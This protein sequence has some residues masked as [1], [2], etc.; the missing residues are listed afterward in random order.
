MLW[1]RR[2][3][4][5][6]W[7]PTRK[8][9]WRWSIAYQD[10]EGVPSSVR[11]HTWMT[12]PINNEK[13]ILEIMEEQLEQVIAPF[14]ATLMHMP[15]PG[16]TLTKEIKSV[17]IDHERR[18]IDVT[19]TVRVTPPLAPWMV[20]HPPIQSGGDQYTQPVMLTPGQR[21]VAAKII[22]NDYMGVGFQIGAD[23][24]DVYVDFLS[25][26]VLADDFMAVTSGD[27]STERKVGSVVHAIVEGRHT[28][29]PKIVGFVDFD[30]A[31]AGDD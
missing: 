25:M 12:L 5:W 26:P 31:T 2:L 10:I 3:W 16:E 17:M 13:R 15:G 24:P 4:R 18:N 27:P 21:R 14:V 9:F 1:A 20:G 7:T 28:T 30:Q 6:F 19:A 8:Y 23:G 11:S 22:C 29:S